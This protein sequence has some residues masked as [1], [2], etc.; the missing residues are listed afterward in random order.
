MSTLVQMVTELEQLDARR[1]ALREQIRTAFAAGEGSHAGNGHHAAPV[2]TGKKRGRKP[3]SKNKNRVAAA[4]GDKRKKLKEI[5]LDILAANP[6]GIELDA[7]VREVIAGG[8]KS[9][10][11][12]AGISNTVY[13]TLYNMLTKIDPS[14]VEKDDKLWKKVG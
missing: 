2:A 14:P 8:Y 3:G 9:R 11:K 1:A 10:G 12:K 13:M 6:N 4:G 5:V 7:V